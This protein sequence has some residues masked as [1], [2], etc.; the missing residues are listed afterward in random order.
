MKRFKAAIASDS[1]SYSAVE[2]TYDEQQYYSQYNFGTT[3][4]HGDMYTQYYPAY[5]EEQ[6]TGT[7]WIL[8]LRAVARKFSPLIFS[9]VFGVLPLSHL[10]AYTL[11]DATFFTCSYLY[12][13]NFTISTVKSRY[14]KN[15][16]FWPS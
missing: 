10:R 12:T 2:M 9:S 1:N 8:K 13:G 7:L 14:S 6:S 15:G 3:Q 16:R 11:Q 5:T 4:M